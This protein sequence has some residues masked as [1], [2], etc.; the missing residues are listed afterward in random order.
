MLMPRGPKRRAPSNT[1]L[2]EPRGLREDP[3]CRPS[4]AQDCEGPAGETRRRK[5]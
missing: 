3:H 2:L 1:P 4:D 5:W